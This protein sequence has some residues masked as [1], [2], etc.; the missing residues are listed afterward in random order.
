MMGTIELLKAMQEKCLRG[1]KYEDP[2]RMEKYHAL[3]KAIKSLEDK[4]PRES[5]LNFYKAKFV[6]EKGKSA[7]YAAA[8]LKMSA[9][10][11]RC[12]TCIHE[13]DA[14]ECSRL[15][16]YDDS[17]CDRGNVDYFKKQAGLE[18]SP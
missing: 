14:P 17:I 16:G 12:D 18:V 5:M 2:L 6:E 10:F 1:G 8:L 9:Y 7:Q 3:E 4:E 15:N 11:R 13:E